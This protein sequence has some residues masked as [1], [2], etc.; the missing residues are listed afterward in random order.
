MA[1]V[2]KMDMEVVITLM[3]FWRVMPL[4]STGLIPMSASHSYFIN[5]SM[6]T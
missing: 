3:P 2:S 4:A 6:A 5:A 1:T